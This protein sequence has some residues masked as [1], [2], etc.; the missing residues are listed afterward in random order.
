MEP[1]VSTEWL[2]SEIG[3]ADLRIV[4]ASNH[5]PDAGRDPRAEYEAGHIPGALFM[6]LASL[7]D[8]ANPVPSALP[9]PEQF[10][11]RMQQL[12]IGDAVAS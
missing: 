5:L 8:T 9:K 6:D 12:G 2:A 11:A 3:A 1:L 4:D 10:A 7:V